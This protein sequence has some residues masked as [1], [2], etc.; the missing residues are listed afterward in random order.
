MRLVI[1]AVSALG[2]LACGP[3]AKI[4]GGKDGAAQAFFLASQPTKAGSDKATTPVDLTGAVAWNCP[5]GGKAE[6][7]GFGVVI[8]GGVAGATVNQ[9]FTLKYDNCGMAKADVGTAV[10]NGGWTVTQGVIAGTGGVDVEQNFK[11]KILVQGA[12]DDFIEVDLTQKVSVT[13]LGSG[14]GSVTMDLNGSIATSTASH[15]YTGSLTVTPGVIQ[16]EIVKN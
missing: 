5:E 16:G 12:F 4:G 14:S 3:G 13:A 8:G 11:S 15:S 6:L 9:S 10:Y 2:L 7:T 1:L